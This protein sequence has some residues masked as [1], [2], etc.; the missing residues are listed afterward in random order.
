MAGLSGN[1]SGPIM[2]AL[3]V[4]PGAQ[5]FWVVKIGENRFSREDG[6]QNGRHSRPS[7]LK[8]FPQQASRDIGLCLGEGA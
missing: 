3:M 8:I 4:L 2:P 7:L 1:P 6:K 5:R